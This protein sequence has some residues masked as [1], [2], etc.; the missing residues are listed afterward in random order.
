M[1]PLLNQLNIKNLKQFEIYLNDKPINLKTIKK[2][3][4]EILW[5]ELIFLKYSKKVKIDKEILIQTIK[6][7]KNEK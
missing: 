7:K 5:N 4:I 6:N 2:I 3:T 1:V